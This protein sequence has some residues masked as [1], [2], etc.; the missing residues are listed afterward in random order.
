MVSH[1]LSPHVLQCSLAH[2]ASVWLSP[3]LCLNIHSSF[4]F[5][6]QAS[7]VVKFCFHQ[8]RLISKAR[9]YVP[10][11]DLGKLI[12]A[13][14]T[15]RLDYCNSLYFGL[16]STLLHRLQIVQN[17]AARLLTGSGRRV[18]ITR[19][20]AD[21]RWLPVKYCIRFK[22]LL[23]TFWIINNIAPS[24]LIE[25]LRSYTPTRALRSSS[26]S[27]LVLPRSQLKT[28]GDRAFALSAPDLWNN[29]PIAIRESDSIQSFKS[30]LKTRLFS[31]AF[32]TS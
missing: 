11:R 4:K 1:L 23:L 26:R 10:H 28:R 13:F 9:H 21:L 30:R 31:L 18:S 25:L 8:L 17:A 24:Y 19:V 16:N 15:S 6:K 7:S 3:T 27:L 22:I 20:L 14:V 5:D 12:H 29:L 32:S 2:L